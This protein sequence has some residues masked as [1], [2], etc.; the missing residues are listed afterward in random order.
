MWLAPRARTF[1]NDF[2]ASR[3][4]VQKAIHLTPQPQDD[5]CRV[6]QGESL[7]SDRDTESR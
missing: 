2:T 3:A 7:A 5:T 4:A 6:I 1:G